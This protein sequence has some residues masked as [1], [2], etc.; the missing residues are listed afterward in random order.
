MSDQAALRAANLSCWSGPVKPSPLSGGITNTNFIIEDAGQKYVVRIGE[1]IPVHGIMRFNE[2]AASNAAHQAGLSPKVIHWEQGVLVLQY[3]E[4]KTLEAAD[5]RNPEMLGRIIALVKKVHHD[6]PRHLEGA[7]L[8]FWVFQVFRNYA[9]VLQSD[10]SRMV[11]TLPRLLEIA[12]ELEK[13]VGPVEMV[14]GHN[15]LLSANFL[16]DGSRLWI[17]DWDYAGFNSPLF[18]LANLA[19]NNEFDEDL[20]RGMLESYFGSP[21]DGTLWHSYRAMKCASLLR[22]TMWSM[23][24]EI[25]SELDF[26]YVSYTSDYMQ[27]FEQALETFRSDT[28]K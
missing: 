8:V 27:R 21:A 4:S 26:D 6:I 9:R 15:D 17:I 11:A 13:A 24:S 16:D 3:I 1:D 5:I 23:V 2:R 25:H 19:S 28:S 20:E 12:D 14:F 18:D 10:G 7:S 22:E